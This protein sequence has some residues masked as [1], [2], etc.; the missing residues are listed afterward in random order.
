MNTKPP[1]Q[2]TPL[3]AEVDR[4]EYLKEAAKK[5]N[6]NHLDLAK[7]TGYSHDSVLSWFTDPSSTR[8]RPVPQRAVDRLKLE[9]DAGRVKGSKF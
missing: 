1:L 4:L 3:S 2:E 9:L 6:L 5:Y 8:H 7:Y